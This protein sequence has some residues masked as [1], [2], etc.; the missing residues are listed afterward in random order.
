VSNAVELKGLNKAFDGIKAVNNLSLEVE[1]GS[2]FGFLGPNGA[3]KTTTIK[4]M[5]GLIKQD[6][7]TANLLG[8]DTGQDILKIKKKVGYVAEIDHLYGYMKVREILEFNQGF[9]NNWDS[10]LVEKYNKFFKLPLDKKIKEL[11]RGM[12]KQLSLILAM[13]SNPELLILD[14]PTSGLDPINRQEILRII[15]EEISVKGRTVFFSTHLLGDVER[16]ADSVAII[17]RG[18]LLEQSLLDDLKSEIKKIRVVFQKEPDPDVLS[19]PGIDNYTQDRNA[20]IISVS[21]NLN[22]ILKKLEQEPHF[23][24]DVIEQNLEDIFID[25][26]GDDKDEI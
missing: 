12:K 13:A 2:I 6:S 3:G 22:Q 24:L 15:L 18:R 26:V 16:I 4:I 17:N 1:E 8:Y 9:Y 19:L 5:L 10:S 7:G 21:K 20:Y 25:K 14:E 11:S 23:S